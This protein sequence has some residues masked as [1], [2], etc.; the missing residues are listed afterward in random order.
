MARQVGVSRSSFWR[1]QRRF[2]EKR[3]DVLLREYSRR[4]GNAPVLQETMRRVI[5]RDR[6]ERRHTGLRRP[7]S[8]DRWPEPAPDLARMGNAPAPN[9]PHSYLQVFH[10]SGLRSQGGECRRPLYESACPC[11]G[12][13]Y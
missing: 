5:T 13:V 1:W 3:V 7:D 8:Q 2:A 4:L 6:R 10:Q 9:S 12:L 11:G